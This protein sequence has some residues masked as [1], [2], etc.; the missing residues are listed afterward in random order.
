MSEKFAFK[1]RFNHARGVDGYER[2]LTPTEAVDM[3]GHDLLADSGFSPEQDGDIRYGGILSFIEEGVQPGPQHQTLA[4]VLLQKDAAQFILL[5]FVFTFLQ[6]PHEEGRTQFR[7]EKAGCAPQF[8]QGKFVSRQNGIGAAQIEKPRR[9]RSDV[10]AEAKA[11]LLMEV[12]RRRGGTL[13][14]DLHKPLHTRP[15]V[16]AFQF[17]SRQVDGLDK[18]QRIILIDRAEKRG[19]FHPEAVNRGPKKQMKPFLKDFALRRGVQR[20]MAP[21]DDVFLFG[22]GIGKGACKQAKRSRRHVQAGE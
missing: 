18:L 12:H 22:F 5:Q 17:K 13:L 1:E 3:P 21:F 14:R 15:H 8:K 19:P 16:L 20:L 9:F 4:P 2:P 7:S 6:S 11:V 10:D